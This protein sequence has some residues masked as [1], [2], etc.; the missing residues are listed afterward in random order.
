VVIYVLL[1]LGLRLFGKREVGQFTPF[2]LVL[3]L[4]VANAVQPAMTGPDTSLLGGF[5]IV[6]VL[7]LINRLVALLRLRHPLFRRFLEGHSTVIAKGG[8][9]LPAALRSEGLD[10]EEANMSLREHGIADVSDVELAVLE[11][12][13]SI[14][15]VP[16]GTPVLRGH[17]RSRYRM[18]P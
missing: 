6:L 18:K 1:L 17:T 7:L 16:I 11:T 3:I 5:V 8:E 9:W 10:E 14:S 13:G 12:D 4:L 15:I 2:D